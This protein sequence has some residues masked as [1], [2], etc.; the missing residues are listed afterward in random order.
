MEELRRASR[1]DRTLPLSQ[2][3]GA[4]WAQLNDTDDNKE[5]I[6]AD[7]GDRRLDGRRFGNLNDN[8]T[9]HFVI[10]DKDGNAVSMTTS[11]NTYFGSNVVSKSSGIVL[12]NTMD[13]FS[14]PGRPNYFGLHPSEANYIA[15]GK[16]PLSSMSP[17][18]VF[19]RYKESGTGKLGNLML[20]LGAS[21]G[22]KIISAVLNVIANHILMGMPLFEAV[23]RPR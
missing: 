21:G 5:A 18:M 3:G 7:E 12:S 15:P 1:D 2:Y 11:V 17:T 10:V 9:S 20:V 8:G 6:D 16:K 4:K 13:D 23:I 14:N 19:R 22:P